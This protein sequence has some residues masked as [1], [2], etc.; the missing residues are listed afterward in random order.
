MDVINPQHIDTTLDQIGGCERIKR[1]LVR[2]SHAA[3]C[4]Q[5]RGRRL[6]LYR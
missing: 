4:M 6:G 3:S 2:P 5:S 1:D